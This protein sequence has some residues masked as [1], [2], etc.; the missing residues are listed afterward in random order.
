MLGNSVHD[1][2]LYLKGSVL[3]N[4]YK[5]VSTVILVVNIHGMFYVSD[6]T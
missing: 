3:H 6:A 4:Q 5:K 1:I 2:G